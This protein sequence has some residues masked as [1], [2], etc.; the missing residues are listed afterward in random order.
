VWIYSTSGF[1]SIVRDPED[2]A[3]LVGRSRV[4][5]DVDKLRVQFLPELSPTTQTLGRDYP[6]RAFAKR[7]DF[8]KAMVAM[9]ESIVYTNF[10]AEIARTQGLGRERVYERV[11]RVMKDAERELADLDQTGKRKLLGF[12]VTRRKPPPSRGGGGR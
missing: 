7:S 5:S 4:R 10:K 11:W 2:D 9:V 1:Y 12:T 8:A 3:R 6:Y